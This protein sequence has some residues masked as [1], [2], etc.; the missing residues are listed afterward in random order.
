MSDGSSHPKLPQAIFT[1]FVWQADLLREITAAEAEAFFSF[2]DASAKTPLDAATRAELTQL[3]PRLW[4]EY[5]KH[6]PPP[7]LEL[8]LL[9]HGADENTRAALVQMISAVH[10]AAHGAKRKSNEQLC[11]ALTRLLKRDETALGDLQAHFQNSRFYE[12]RL[13]PEPTGKETEERVS[14]PPTVLSAPI[15]PDLPVLGTSEAATGGFAPPN[16]MVAASPGINSLKENHALTESAPAELTVAPMSETVFGTTNGTIP[17]LK[18][19]P[20]SEHDAVN[21]ERLQ[22]WTKGA[23]PM[24]CIGIIERNQ[25][26]KSFQFVS[27]E[28]TLFFY[29]P[30]Q[31]V[32]LELM[33]DGKRAL[34]SYTISSSPSRPHLIEISVKRV[35][36]GLVSNYLHDRLNIGDT[37]TMKPPGGKFH[38]FDTVT[39]KYL[40]LAAGSGITPMLS[41]ARWW[42]D[43]GANADVIFF[44]SVR[45]PEDAVFAEDMITFT[46]ANRKFRYM[47]SFT[48][49][50][51]PENWPGMKGRLNEEKLLKIAPDFAERTIFSC[52]PD[53]FMKNLRL[54]LEAKNFPVKERFRQESFGTPVALKETLPAESP[55]KST[56]VT[57]TTQPRVQ[58][59][60]RVPSTTEQVVHFSLSALEV[61][62]GDMDVTILD[63]AEEVG[64]E[65]PS[66]C[67]SGTCGTCRAMKIKGE[68]E[69]DDTPGLTDAD[70][71][72]GYILTC[73][74]RAKSY[75]EIEV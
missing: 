12:S 54:I 19:V 37:I 75:V 42:H 48:S 15:A 55:K 68:I 64:V 46:G 32:T 27:E 62:G 10:G 16:P 49:T 31:F 47:T 56:P 11:S 36:N 60:I 22:F 13:M 65:I 52:G 74:S 61:F 25:D 50:T 57:A 6:G 41:M 72:A 43:T 69:C 23:R 73:V 18:M 20:W 29:K 26:F 4:R 2:I 51:L 59:A 14:S 8:S 67:R 34:R 70:R 63:L 21:P 71:E 40:F 39:D 28:P 5:V 44:H 66:S 9:T 3:Y 1:F 53:S 35:K 17:I 33:I 38:C 45:E 58:P 30:G 7:P 24:R